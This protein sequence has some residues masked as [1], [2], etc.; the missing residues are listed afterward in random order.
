MTA[1]VTLREKGGNKTQSR[2]AQNLPGTGWCSAAA[3]D[4]AAIG[5]SGGLSPARLLHASPEMGKDAGSFAGPV[6]LHRQHGDQHFGNA[7]DVNARCQ[8]RAGRDQE[9]S[10]FVSREPGSSAAPVC[11]RGPAWG[12]PSTPLE[13]PGLGG[14]PD[15]DLHAMDFSPTLFREVLVRLCSLMSSDSEKET[16]R[17]L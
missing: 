14:H 3:F 4:M 15:Q 16:L 17:F 5:R 1:S 13:G 9:E 12:E 2:G 10:H 7:A 6:S 11:R 8:V